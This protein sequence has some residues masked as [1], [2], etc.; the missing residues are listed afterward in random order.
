[1]ERLEPV[2]PGEVLREDYLKPMGMS[3]NRLAKGLGM[4]R[5]AVAE[6]LSGK[7]AITA[8]TALRLSRFFG[9]SARFWM[10]LQVAYDLEVAEQGMAVEL[11]SIQ[12]CE[13]GEGAIER[14][15]ELEDAQA[16]AA[17]T[18]AA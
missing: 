4:S 5:T 15:F 1:M 9:A 12:R 18:A 7:R 17:E 14:Y 11:G 8:A 6:I 13:R 16:P 3:P 10:N 2:H